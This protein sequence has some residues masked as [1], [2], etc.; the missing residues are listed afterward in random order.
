MPYSS[1]SKN[2]CT[3]CYEKLPGFGSKR[4]NYTNFCNEH[5]YYIGGGMCPIC[6]TNIRTIKCEECGKLY[7]ETEQKLERLINNGGVH[8]CKECKNKAIGIGNILRRCARCGSIVYVNNSFSACPNCHKSMIEYDVKCKYCG[9]IFK[10]FISSTPK[11]C[12]D[13]LKDINKPKSVKR[14]ESMLS[15]KNFYLENNIIMA[16]T[17]TKQDKRG[18]KERECLRCGRRLMPV[19]PRQKI[20]KKCF[21]INTC[22]NCGAKFVSSHGGNT[23]FCSPN[24]SAKKQIRNS[25]EEHIKSINRRIK[26]LGKFIFSVLMY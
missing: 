14:L 12:E 21:I 20:C 22:E 5:G 15:S 24:C 26:R 11:I 1:F 17:N 10:S 18:F 8:V 7:V 19:S 6:E 9:K 16:K 23:R 4:I 2:I 3:E 13:C 25:D